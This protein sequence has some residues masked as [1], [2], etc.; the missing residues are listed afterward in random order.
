MFEQCLKLALKGAGLSMQ[1]LA[2]I[3]EPRVSAQAIS[4]FEA[5]LMLPSSTTLVALGN[6]LDVSLDF[7]MSPRIE[8]LEGL[9]F[10]KHSFTSVRD[11]AKAEAILIDNLDRYLAI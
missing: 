8:G 9:E 11:R 10:R 3:M 4:K 1:Q 6:A 2:E 7:L 5:Q